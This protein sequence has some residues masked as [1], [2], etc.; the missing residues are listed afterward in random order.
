M[1]ASARIVREYEGVVPQLCSGETLGEGTGLSWREVDFAK[2]DAQGITETT[3][4]DNPQQLSDSPLSVT[5]TVIAVH[6]VV[7]DRVKA[8]ISKNALAK[9]GPLAQNAVQ[10][11][12]SQDGNAA[13]DGATTSLCGTGTTLTTGHL[14]AAASRV[15]F[16]GGNEPSNPPFYTVLHPYQIKDIYDDIV[17]GVGTYTIPEGETARV[18][19]EGFRGAVDGSMIYEDALITIDGTPD[20]KGGSFAKEA[21]VLVQG[22]APRM[23]NLRNEK[24]G[25]GADEV[26]LYD[27]YAYGERSS[28]NWLYEI[29]SD[30]TAPTS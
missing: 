22:R 29:Q 2:L 1:V 13:I 6:T 30:A 4:L 5:P 9:I 14:A 19:K 18:F 11:K 8:R 12:K 28:G 7:T 23:V 24:L 27:E 15:R 10:R 21:L 25:G 17:A 3:Q 26:I 16:G 20:V